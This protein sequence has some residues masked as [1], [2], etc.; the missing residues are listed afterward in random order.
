M[1]SHRLVNSLVVLALTL[2][3]VGMTGSAA[4][5]TALAR[6]PFVGVWRAIDF[7]DGSLMRATILGPAGG[8]FLITWTESYFTFCDGRAG[9]ATGKGQ[10]NPNDAQVLE[11]DLRLK[12]F[13][14]GDEVS[15]HQIWQYRP[16]HDDLVSQEAPGVE[17]IWK[18]LSQPIVPRAT[19]V[20]Y[21]PGAAEGYDW[22]MGHTITL[23]IPDRGH[24]TQAVSEQEPGSPEGET[25]VLFELWRDD[26]SLEAGDHLFL[27]DE[28][29]GLTKDVVVTNLAVTG[30][31]L[32][33]GTV[34][35]AFD[36]ASDLWVWLYGQEGQV[37]ASEGD[38]WT[39]TFAELPPGAW[40]GAT[41]WDVDGDGTSIDFQ[42]PNPHFSVF[43]EQ[44][45]IEGWR[46][47]DGAT[48]TAS[49][50]GKAECSADGVSDHPEWDPQGLFVSMRFPEGCDVTAGDEVR[51]TGDGTT[52]THIVQNL[53]VTSVDAAADVVAGTADNGAE[54]HVWVH[55][56]GESD[57]RVSTQDGSWEAAF[58]SIPFDLLLGMCGRSEIQD[59]EGNATAVDWCVPAAGTGDI[60][61]VPDENRI[62]ANSWI[63]GG[64]ISLTIFDTG[65]AEL[66]SESRLVPPPSE[67]PWTEVLFESG[68]SLE[69]GQRIVIHQGS[70]ER[71]LT[72]SSIR[73]TG[74]DLG[75]QTVFGTGD[76]G[77]SFYVEIEGE[78]EWATVGEDGAWSV[79]HEDLTGGVWGSAI[80]PDGDWDSTRD[81]F[82]APNPNFYAVPDENRIYA[83]EWIEGAELSLTIFGT[84]GGEVYSESRLVP[85]P[86][87]RPWTLV[88]F[89][90]GFVLQSGQRI[91]LNQGGYERE[92]TVSSIRVTGFDLGAQAVSGTGDPGAAF[93]VR[94]GGVDE[95]GTVGDDGTWWVHNG[96]LGPA[97]WGEAIQPDADGDATRDGFQAPSS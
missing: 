11:A 74:F 79:H 21:V 16:T 42:V 67:R 87:E 5:A 63:E 9:V 82:G 62:W 52:R 29:I 94:I 88:I 25:R 24:T 93:F 49:V 44:E 53:A 97:V 50:A 96:N 28:S 47:P 59:A 17:T 69:P 54:V 10:L 36:P 30:F 20:A 77:A 1:K 7:G 86:S 64:E 3:T 91:M 84:E 34:T 32:S 75:G 27:T 83:N 55:E 89:E 78:D 12:C 41:Q 71:E 43:P 73:V 58:G 4:S 61:A 85:P 13:R 39:A 95:W 80:Q 6:S 40:G 22:P 90:S 26:V 18:R 15:W 46:W 45:V 57:I 8:P 14:T 2:S 92:L 19:F 72:V 48:V 68:F 81:I 65:G 35:G 31:D 66:Y 38:V 37:A 70:Y 51:L 60:Y 76:P 56:F 33:A 23:S